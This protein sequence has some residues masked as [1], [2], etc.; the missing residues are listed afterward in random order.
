MSSATAT[1]IATRTFIGINFHFFLFTF[2]FV[3]IKSLSRGIYLYESLKRGIYIDTFLI[4]SYE[5]NSSALL[6]PARS[7]NPPLTFSLLNIQEGCTL[8][9]GC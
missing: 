5:F 7:S 9:K 6:S 2:G 1:L 8:N 3:C 4:N